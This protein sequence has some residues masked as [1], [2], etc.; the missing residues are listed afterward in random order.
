[1]KMVRILLISILSSIV[2]IGIDW[3]YSFPANSKHI[4]YS[5]GELP[6]YEIS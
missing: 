5:K 1:M 2:L 3:D 4:C 6:K